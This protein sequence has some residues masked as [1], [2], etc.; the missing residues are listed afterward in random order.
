MAEI[1]LITGQPGHGKSL[2][3]ITLGLAF[4]AE[5]RPVYA[6]G[7]KDLDYAA[8]GFLPLPDDFRAFDPREKDDNGRQLVKWQQLPH[9]A[10]IILDEC[11][12]YIPQRG[13]GKPVP[14]HID[15]MA[16]HRHTGHDIIL[17][18]QK[19][20]QIDGFVKGLIGT[21]V[22][23]RR[24]FG[25]NAAVLRTWDR[26]SSNTMA[27]DTVA[28]ERWVYPKKNF[29]LYKSATVHSVKRKTPWFVWFLPVGVA[30]VVGLLWLTWHNF[31]SMGEPPAKAAAV[32]GAYAPGA[33]AAG[34]GLAAA[35]ERMRANNWPAWMAPRV[36]GQPWTAPAWDGLQ[37]QGV[38]DLYCIAVDDGR[39][40]CIT[41]QGTAYRVD[42]R[43]CQSIALNGVYN[44]FRRPLDERQHRG[45]DARDSV[46]ADAAEYRPVTEALGASSPLGGYATSTMR[47]DYVPAELTRAPGG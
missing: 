18:T 4:V 38:P 19:H 32:T 15:S 41:E 3:A 7:F 31:S 37:P 29:T 10:V 20:D 47:Q 25:W 1:K 11:Y 16:R 33:V 8:T 23:V 34:G 13:A 2:Y 9:G 21:H 12:D 28:T 44:P 35:D 27:T 43:V 6:A 46:P 26:F 40:K 42:H 36:A 24:K 22:H 14:P 45:R 30:A 5:G 17:V 39:C